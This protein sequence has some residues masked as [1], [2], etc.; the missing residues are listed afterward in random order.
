TQYS[1]YFGAVGYS[2][3]R[4]LVENDYTEALRAKNRRIEFSIV[5]REEN[6]GQIIQEYLDSLDD[7]S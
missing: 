2:E 7:A 3:S 1:S 6:V 4:P 5:V